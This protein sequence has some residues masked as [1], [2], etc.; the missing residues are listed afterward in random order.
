MDRIGKTSGV[1]LIQGPELR[2]I[3]IAMDQARDELLFSSIKGKNPLKDVRVRRALG[4]RSTRRP[5]SSAC[6]AARA[7]PAG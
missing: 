4:W 7:T 6:C 3:Y 2:T 5:S 1:R